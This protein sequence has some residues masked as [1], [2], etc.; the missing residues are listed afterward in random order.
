MT[1][2]S[3]SMKPGLV[4]PPHQHPEEEFMVVTE[5]SGEIR[6]DGKVTNVMAGSMMYCAAGHMHGIANTGAAAMLFYFYKW[7]K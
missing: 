6:V 2:G 3:V 7:I 4:H 5:G 1:A